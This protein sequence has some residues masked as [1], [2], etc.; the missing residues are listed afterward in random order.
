M[1]CSKIAVIA[2]YKCH[3]QPTWCHTSFITNTWLYWILPYFTCWRYL[4]ISHSYRICIYTNVTKLILCNL[5][6][7]IDHSQQDL[8][9]YTVYII[10]VVIDLDVI[11]WHVLHYCDFILCVIST[12]NMI[13]T[14]MRGGS[15]AWHH[16]SGPVVAIWI[17][18]VTYWLSLDSETEVSQ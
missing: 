1:S 7:I 15:R 4:P 16:R 8:V 9:L 17:G 3:F 6:P 13:L 11:K 12:K 18:N 2:S 5:H 10:P 14:T